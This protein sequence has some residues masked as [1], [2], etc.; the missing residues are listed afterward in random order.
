ML[1]TPGLVSITFRD[2]S[3]REI[4]NLVAE[5]ALESIEWGG[6][7]HV[8]PGDAAN[9]REV[10]RMTAD[11]GLQ[12][13]AYGSY[14]R[15]IEAD[16]STPEFESTLVTAVELGAP[17]I[18]VWAGC[19]DSE[20]V[21]DITFGDLRD[22]LHRMATSA[23]AQDV[24]IA[25]EFHGGTYTNTTESTL[26]LLDTVN[27]PNLTTL[28]QPPVGMSEAD[29]LHSLGRC[30]RRT[31]NVHA[32]HWHP[33]RDKRPLADGYA[34]WSA[35]VAKLKE[36]ALERHILLEFVKDGTPSQFKSDAATLRRLLS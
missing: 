35:Y 1:L 31:S 9:A 11:A 28:W 17:T 25:L 15:I 20:N 32:F 2:R 22:R 19:R 10:R 33:D 14:F 6:D 21:D 8:L 26:R 34:T 7:V 36:S 13:A 30:I 3:P 4:V 18:R 16:G 23:E 29:C 12:V 5:A 24:R 27:H